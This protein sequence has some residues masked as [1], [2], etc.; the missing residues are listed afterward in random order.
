MTVPARNVK[1]DAW[2]LV[3][4]WAEMT[5]CGDFDVSDDVRAHILKAVIP[6]IRRKATIIRRATRRRP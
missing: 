1:A 4:S 3:A 6:A 5:A 2:D